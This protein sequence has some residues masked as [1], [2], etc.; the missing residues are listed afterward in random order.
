[1]AASVWPI[2]IGQLGAIVAAGI[3]GTLFLPASTMALGTPHAVNL[4]HATGAAFVVLHGT[5]RFG[6]HNPRIG[7]FHYPTRPDIPA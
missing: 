5:S 3:I 6:D 2:A 4:R 7:G 1:M